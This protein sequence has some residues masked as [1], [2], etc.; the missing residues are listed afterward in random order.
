MKLPGACT[1]T[2]H[3]ASPAPTFGCRQ[4]AFMTEGNTLSPAQKVL[5]Q[6]AL[7]ENPNCLKAQSHKR[8]H[9]LREGAVMPFHEED[10]LNDP[11]DGNVDGWGFA[12]YVV[13]SKTPVEIQR[14]LAP[15]CTDDGFDAAAKSLVA[16][17]PRTMLAHL[18]NK[19]FPQRMLGEEDLHPFSLGNWTGMFNGVL[20]GGR[21]PDLLKTLEQTFYPLLGAKPKG[22]NSGERILLYYLGK[23]KQR[24]GTLDGELLSIPAMQQAFAETLR[25]FMSRSKPVYAPVA[26]GT[27]GGLMGLKGQ[28]QDGPS[29]NYVVSDGQ[30]L[31]AYRKG[32]RLYLNRHPGLKGRVG[33]VVSSEPFQPKQGG[34]LSWTELPEDHILTLTRLNDGRIHPTLTPFSVALKPTA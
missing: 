33:Y 8:S 19:L 17:G 5:W 26:A 6:D 34:K 27:E 3:S 22:T 11:Q 24:F 9:P 14:S 12:A 29:C 28:V 7:V 1:I 23:L 15:A 32:R 20:T 18:L 4:M 10:L 16:K 21:S 13:R 2:R 25:D 30:T 31:M